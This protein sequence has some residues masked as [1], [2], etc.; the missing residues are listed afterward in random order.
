M[1]QSLIRRW[2]TSRVPRIVPYNPDALVFALSDP[3]GSETLCGCHVSTHENPLTITNFRKS[4]YEKTS[5]ILCNDV[6]SIKGAV[7][8]AALLA[9][10][11][12]YPAWQH[13]R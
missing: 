10:R 2:L 12:V 9:K 1:N 13:R 5:Y 8:Y 3:D 4:V 11:F 6:L 7:A